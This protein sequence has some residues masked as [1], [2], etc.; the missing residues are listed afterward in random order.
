MTTPRKVSPLVVILGHV[1][2]DENTIEGRFYRSWGSPAMYV[3]AYYAREYGV[4]THI[5]SEY[6][7][8]F[9]EYIRDFTLMAIE[10][11]GDDTLIYNN[12]I[13]NGHRTQFC[14]NPED[15]LPVQLDEVMTKLIA[16][17]DIFIVAPD[18]PNYA[19]VYMREAIS[20][21]KRGCKKIL[22]PQGLLREI[23]GTLVSRGVLKNPDIVSPFDVTIISDEDIDSAVETAKLWSEKYTNTAIIVTRAKNG[24]ALLKNGNTINIPTEHPLN[25]S[26]I[27][28]PVGAGDMFS[29]EVAM[30]LFEGLSMEKS[31]QSAHVSTARILTSRSQQNL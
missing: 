18:I 15:S 16:C 7:A 27:I 12:N 2:I 11:K 28:N 3:A 4:K 10:P 9:T 6:G 30:K 24:A 8:D 20:Y 23:D 17:A 1:C 22:M 29:A 14:P 5:I 31:I 19:D 21:T 26:E 13:E 25:D